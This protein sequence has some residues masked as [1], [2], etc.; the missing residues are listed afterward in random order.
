MHFACIA[1]FA[2]FVEFAY[3]FP[4]GVP[5]D[6]SH[7]RLTTPPQHLAITQPTTRAPIAEFADFLEF[8]YFFLQ[9]GLEILHMP[10]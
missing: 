1:E 5:G 8:A 2:D 7:A 10:F 4:P 9:G 6:S 3:F